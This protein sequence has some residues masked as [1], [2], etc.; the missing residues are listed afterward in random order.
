VP[1]TPEQVAADNALTDAIE[2]VARAYADDGEAWVMSEYVVLT[3]QH[4]YD[5]EGDGL[6]AVGVL[7]RDGDVPL[8][9]AL[10]LVDYAATRIRKLIATDDEDD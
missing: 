8:H 7:Y 10:G 9:R 5:D 2:Q 6:T 1:R 4:R 3:A